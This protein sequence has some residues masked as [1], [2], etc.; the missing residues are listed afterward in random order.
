MYI[1]TKM[2]HLEPFQE[3]GAKWVKESGRGGEFKYNIFDTL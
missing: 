1:N 3:S 2:I